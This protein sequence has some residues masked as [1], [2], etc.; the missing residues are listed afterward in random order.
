MDGP[1]LAGVALTLCLGALL[2]AALTRGARF[3][4]PVFTL[5]VVFF[6][7]KACIDVRREPDDF[8]F[9]L[10][11]TWF[12]IGGREAG[13]H[14]VILPALRVAFAY[15]ALCVAERVT[16]FWPTRA[17]RYWPMVS[18]SILGYGLFGIVVELVNEQCGWWTWRH[19]GGLRGIHY[20][21]QW[22]VWASGIFEAIYVGWVPWRRIRRPWMLSAGLLAGF[23]ALLIA[24]SV[25]APFLRTVIL[26][27]STVTMMGVGFVFRGPRLI[28]DQRERA[29]AA[30][31]VGDS[32][33]GG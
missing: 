1:I 15:L 17:L 4:V 28:L 5:L 26:L 25:F 23:Y 3:T 6:G 31:A 14:L 9:E 24:I 29:A 12:A 2:H 20:L 21:L 33:G 8:P 18:A 13:V 10:H 11:L 7:L 19:L 22:A 30:V 16:A 27:S 32:T